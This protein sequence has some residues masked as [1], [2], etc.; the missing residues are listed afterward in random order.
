[1]L[2]QES[3]CPSAP[4]VGPSKVALPAAVFGVTYFASAFLRIS[5]LRSKARVSSC[6]I[7]GQS[8]SL[9]PARPTMLG[10]DSVTP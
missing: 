9:T 1:L 3:A 7:S 5:A 10:S 4:R 2:D 8:T 6:D